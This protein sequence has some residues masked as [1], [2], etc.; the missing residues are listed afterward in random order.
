[1]STATDCQYSHIEKS[2]RL[3][4]IFTHS[5][6]KLKLYV[7]SPRTGHL[8]AATLLTNQIS[9]LNKALRA[10]GAYT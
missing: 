5:F 10:R 2:A 9:E 4:A 1:M 6:L 3:D 8:L 7:T